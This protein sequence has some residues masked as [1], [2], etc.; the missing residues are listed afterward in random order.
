MVCVAQT[1]VSET[2]IANRERFFGSVPLLYI[3]PPRS[4]SGGK[5]L[6]CELNVCGLKYC[7]ITEGNVHVHISHNLLF[8]P[9]TPFVAAYLG[10]RTNTAN[11]RRM[12]NA[13][14]LLHKPKSVH[15]TEDTNPD[16]MKYGDFVRLRWSK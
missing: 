6:G 10:T 13:D 7:D 9:F 14:N 1:T 5:D 12:G 15:R 11:I 16:A 8:M 3:P 2:L 4:G